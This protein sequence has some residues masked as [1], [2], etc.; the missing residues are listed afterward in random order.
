[1]F[2]K[3]FWL[4]NII[5][6]LKE[7]ASTEFQEKGWVKAEIHPYCRFA[8]TISRLYE[9]G[10]FEEF[11]SDYAKDFGFTQ[12]QIQK[13]DKLCKALNN[14]ID[15]HGCY[16]EPDILIEDPEWHKI[17]EMAKDALKALNIEKYLDPSKSI[18]KDCLLYRTNNIAG[19]ENQKSFWIKERSFERNPFQE[20]LDA[21]FYTCKAGEV[22]AHYKD[23]EMTDEQYRI[24]KLFYDHLFVYKE[25]KGKE[26]DLQKILND[27]E[28]HHIQVLAHKA[29]KIFEFKNLSE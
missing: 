13:L 20:L 12:N 17:R 29:L 1:M 21:F 4:E 22:I 26:E 23:Y 8:D 15:L 18:F 28:W 24:L 7:I 19:L 3:E 16:E 10:F 14:F 9:N 2:P 27:P 11:I 6:P 5:D 25:K